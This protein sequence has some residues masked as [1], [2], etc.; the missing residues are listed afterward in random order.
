MECSNQLGFASLIGTFHLSPHENILT[1]ALIN[2]H[3]LYN[4]CTKLMKLFSNVFISGVWEL[5]AYDSHT[6]PY[7]IFN[8][9]NPDKL[10][11]N[12][13]EDMELVFTFLPVGKQNGEL[14][15]RYEIIQSDR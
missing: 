10:C 4:D 1:I 3:Y 14:I 7:R 5:F 13:T 12:I 8:Q 9:P 6:L 2:I 11:Y 15:W